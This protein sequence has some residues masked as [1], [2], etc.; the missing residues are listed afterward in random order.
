MCVCVCV[1]VRACVCVCLCVYVC[2][3]VRVF[4]GRCVCAHVCVLTN[5]AS[6]YSRSTFYRLKY[7]KIIMAAVNLV[8]YHLRKDTCSI[9]LWC[10]NFKNI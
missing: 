6:S 5:H 4:G 9:I 2:V 7:Y 3:Y 1:C 8:I 10:N